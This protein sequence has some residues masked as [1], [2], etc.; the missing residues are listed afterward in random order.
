MNQ[1]KGSKHHR[2]LDS[3]RGRAGRYLNT[4]STNSLLSPFL[5]N[6]LSFCTL[7]NFRTKLEGT[8]GFNVLEPYFR[9]NSSLRRVSK[10]A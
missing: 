1:R 6:N 3:E 5:L 8:L 7:A 2:G 10:P 9:V 4:L